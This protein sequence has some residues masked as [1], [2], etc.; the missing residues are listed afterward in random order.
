MSFMEIHPKNRSPQGRTAHGMVSI[1]LRFF[2]VYGGEGRLEEKNG[3]VMDGY[4]LGDIWIYDVQ[5]MEWT[6]I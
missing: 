2:L 5:E 3:K 4:I 6:E 1:S